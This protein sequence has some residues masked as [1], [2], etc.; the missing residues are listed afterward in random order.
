MHFIAAAL[1]YVRSTR[2]VASGTTT[3]SFTYTPQ[4]NVA[5]DNRSG[6]VSLAF[7]Y[8]GD[9]RLAQV[10]NLAA[11]QASYALNALGQR[12]LKTIPGAPPTSVAFHYG[13][14][15]TLLAESDGQG[16]PL[17]EYLYL[18]G[19]PVAMASG[20]Q[21]YDVHPD[22]LGAPQQITD[23][24]QSLVWDE[25]FPPF[26]QENPPIAGTVTNNLRF[27]GQYFDQETALHYNYFRDYDASIGRYVESDPIGLKGELR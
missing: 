3:R 12:V 27:P 1:R 18:D 5:N 20:G 24:S 17:R 7:A 15:G 21:L 8:N 25:S 26:G 2:P 10:S 6:A 4:G 14:D 13:R 23:A 11:V 16:N 9:N 19:A 22:H